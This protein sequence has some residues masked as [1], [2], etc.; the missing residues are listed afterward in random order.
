MKLSTLL[1]AIALAITVPSA[2]GCAIDGASFARYLE[3]YKGQVVT[4]EYTA[5]QQRGESKV[6]I[7]NDGAISGAGAARKLDEATLLNLKRLVIQ[8]SFLSLAAK[9]ECGAA[10]KC[11]QDAQVGVLTVT[12][13]G[14]AKTIVIDRGVAL[15][16][17]PQALADV[18]QEIDVVVAAQAG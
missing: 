17:I 1:A 10:R 12:V 9:Y 4:I 18:L 15:E 14:R 16:S 8:P 3:P 11:L 6:S 7:A 5:K 2:T 13:D